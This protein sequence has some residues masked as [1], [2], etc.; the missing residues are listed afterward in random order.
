[1]KWENRDIND[2]ERANIPKFSKVDDI[3]TPLRHRKLFFDDVL[4]DMIVGYTKLYIHRQK[5]DIRF[6]IPNEKN[7]LFLSMLLLSGCQKV[8]DRKLCWESKS[9]V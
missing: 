3:V 2:V 9:I 6:E 1:M 8:P 7:R 4:A 5:T